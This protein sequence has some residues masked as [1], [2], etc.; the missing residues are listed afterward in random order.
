MGAVVLTENQIAE[1][2]SLTV[3]MGSHRKISAAEIEVLRKAQRPDFSH[4]TEDEM[5]QKYAKLRGEGGPLLF[6]KGDFDEVQN[7]LR[8]RDNQIEFQI[9]TTRNCFVHYLETGEIPPPY[10]PF[11]IAVIL[12]RAKLI[13]REKFFL[14][15]WLKH[16]AGVVG[17]RYADLFERLEKLNSKKNNLVDEHS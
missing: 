16:F 6:L 1:V 3:L 15:A 10:Y 14:E 13:L 12:R 5:K 17:G 4:D 7:F 2:D 11:R 8:E 9:E